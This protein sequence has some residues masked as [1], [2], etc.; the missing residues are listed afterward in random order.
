[1]HSRR[2]RRSPLAR[3]STQAGSLALVA[4]L[5]LALLNFNDASP[6]LAD[7]GTQSFSGAPSDGIKIDSNRTTFTYAAS[8]GQALEDAYIVLNDGTVA[9]DITISATDAFNAEDGSF[10]LFDTN[11]PAVDA[12]TWVSFEGAPNQVLTLQPGETRV[13][14][15]VV[16]VPVDASPGDHA[17]GVLATVSSIDGQVKLERRV[18]TRM[19]I[20]VSGDI[21]AGLTVSGLNATY[22]PSLNPFNGD[23]VLTFTV[24]NT[25][26]VTLASRTTSTATGIFGIGL[27]GNA[28]YTVPALLPGSTHVVTTAI[29]GVWQWIWMNA[30]MT[31]VG[32]DSNDTMN[33]GVMPT[34]SREA[35]TWAMPWGL[36][37][38]LIAAGFVYVYIRFSRKNNE[39]RSQQWL[40]YTQAEARLRARD[41]S[42]ES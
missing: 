20:R 14:P 27:S 36:F 16:T 11:M 17:G 39:L 2:L 30:K 42:P 23:L 29:P 21:E 37:A 40:E 22:Q 9:Q 6:A 35:S 15:F 38:L 25:G 10:A 12:G 8:P 24:Q 4:F 5:S 28:S 3:V 7:E 31:L 33:A 18:A 19:N 34:A 13:I 32:V 1:M 26:N 41:E